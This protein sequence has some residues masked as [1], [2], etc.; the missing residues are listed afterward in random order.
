MRQSSGQSLRECGS[1][2]RVSSPEN[3]SSH[4]RSS[5]LVTLVISK[6]ARYNS[7]LRV[8]IGSKAATASRDG[9]GRAARLQHQPGWPG[10]DSTKLLWARLASQ[11][12]TPLVPMCIPKLCFT[13]CV[14]ARYQHMSYMVWNAYEFRKARETLLLINTAQCN[15]LKI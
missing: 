1:D 10:Q 9:Q 13:D 11:R 12:K 7:K 5:F 4:L 2:P 15:S 14:N 3:H 8:G 6:G